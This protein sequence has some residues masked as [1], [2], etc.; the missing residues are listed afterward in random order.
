VVESD[1]LHAAFLTTRRVAT[2]FVVGALLLFAKRAWLEPLLEPALPTLEVRVARDAVPVE[3]ERARDR[4][5]LAAYAIEHGALEADPVVQQRL[6]ED[7]GTAQM[8]SSVLA[9]AGRTLQIERADPLIRE[10]LAWHGEQLLRA[11]V[12][13]AEP[14]E[15][16]LQT[17]LDVHAT[18][19]RVP[20]R[21]SITHILIASRRGE[22]QAERVAQ[23]EAEIARGLTWQ[24]A[25]S[26]SDASILPRSLDHVTPAELDETFGAGF[27][28]A[29]DALSEA[30]FAGPISSRY[31][32]HFVW[33]RE[34]TQARTAKLS[35]LHARVL[36]DYLNDARR[37]ATAR[38]VKEL[39]SRYRLAMIR[40]GA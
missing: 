16:E 31:G 30:R 36:A 32:T 37:D 8:S 38:A 1:V 15:R 29:L 17:Y 34:R 3:I 39:A 12:V 33:V 6:R 27:G 40:E 26:W 24:A 25:Q 21:F 23:V 18:R 35:D 13:V 22:A 14:N 10:R 11:R 5:V 2:F 4:A 19:Y 20:A 7:L 28:D 9:Q